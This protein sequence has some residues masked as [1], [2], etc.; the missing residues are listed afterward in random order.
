MTPELKAQIKTFVPWFERRTEVDEL[1][2]I[3]TEAGKAER[4]ATKTTLERKTERLATTSALEELANQLIVDVERTGVGEEVKLLLPNGRWIRPFGSYV[5]LQINKM[6]RTEKT[7]GGI[8]LQ[9]A[10]TEWRE[11]QHKV[12]KVVAMGS[13]AY[14]GDRFPFGPWVETG[15]F[16]QFLKYNAHDFDIQIDGEKYPFV[17]L[18]DD[19]L[20]SEL[21]HE[22]LI[23]TDKTMGQ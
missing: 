19:K 12:A 10:N 14:V 18:Y 13:T 15:M 2:Q 22:D 23:N 8:I 1:V 20:L 17:I 16:V 5:I 3:E 4:P 6:A 21:S 9:Y 7:K 11:M